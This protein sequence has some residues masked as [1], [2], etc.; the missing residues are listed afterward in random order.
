M[1]L[2]AAIVNYYHEGSTLC[3]HTDH[4]EH[5]LEPPVISLSFGMPA[6]FLIGGK[7]HIT[8]D[9]YLISIPIAKTWQMYPAVVFRLDQKVFVSV[10]FRRG[11]KVVYTPQMNP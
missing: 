3:A 5:N 10:T 11:S 8:L 2:Q 6:V 7:Y 4:S 9:A 1:Y